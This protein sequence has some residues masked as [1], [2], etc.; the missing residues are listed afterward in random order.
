M[1]KCPSVQFAREGAKSLLTVAIE[2]EVTEF[3]QRRRYERRSNS[4]GYHNGHRGRQLICGAGEIE[5]AVPRP[6]DASQ[7][8]I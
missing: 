4:K 7:P 1:E 8:F 2:E 6:S 3:L 5:L